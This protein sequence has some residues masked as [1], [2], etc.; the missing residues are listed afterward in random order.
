MLPQTISVYANVRSSTVLVQKMTEYT[1]KMIENFDKT[2]TLTIDKHC[3]NLEKHREHKVALFCTIRTSSGRWRN[4]GSYFTTFNNV[5]IFTY[6]Q[7]AFLSSILSRCFATYAAIA[8][9]LL[10]SFSH[11][12]MA[13]KTPLMSLQNNI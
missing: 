5:S 9:Y 13:V 1:Q 10:I 8:G 7:T 12:F 3:F 2:T 11:N 6:F 4:S